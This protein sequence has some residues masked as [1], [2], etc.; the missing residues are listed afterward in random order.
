M[1][2]ILKDPTKSDNY[3]SIRAWVRSN[4]LTLSIELSMD[5]PLHFRC[6]GYKILYSI[7]YTLVGFESSRGH[8]AFSSGE[9]NSILYQDIRD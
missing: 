7:Q 1:Q 2:W 9:T 8:H 4:P 6:L 5:V 3:S